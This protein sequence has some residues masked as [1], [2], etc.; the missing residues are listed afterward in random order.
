MKVSMTY[1]RDAVKQYL[2][3]GSMYDAGLK[4][5]MKSSQE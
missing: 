2:L 4:N 3:Y 5:A 1:P